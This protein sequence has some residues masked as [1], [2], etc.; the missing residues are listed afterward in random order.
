MKCSESEEIMI[1]RLGWK[2]MENGNRRLNNQEIRYLQRRLYREIEEDQQE[3][4]TEDGDGIRLSDRE[5]SLRSPGMIRSRYEQNKELLKTYQTELL[6]PGRIEFPKIGDLNQLSEY[7]K[8]R[9]KAVDPESGT[10]LRVFLSFLRLKFYIAT[11]KWP[12]PRKIPAS[13]IRKLYQK[14]KEDQKRKIEWRNIDIGKKRT[15]IRNTA[16]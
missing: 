12:N 1:G 6:Y 7:R 5:I 16:K 9:R 13:E 11:G 15:D 3:R 8:Y 2:K 4:E 14:W 10:N